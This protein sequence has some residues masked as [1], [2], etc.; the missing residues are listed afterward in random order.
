MENLGKKTNYRY[1][2]QKQNTRDGRE[3]LRRREY[4][5]RN[6]SKKMLNLKIF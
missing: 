2:H 5:K 4:D 1:K 6:W 3:N